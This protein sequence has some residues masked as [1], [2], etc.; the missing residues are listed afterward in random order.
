MQN[1]NDLCEENEHIKFWENCL[2]DLIKQFEIIFQ[3]YDLTIKYQ[4][5]RTSDLGNILNKYRNDSKQ[6]TK[7]PSHIYYLC[8][9]FFDFQSCIWGI[10]YKSGINELYN[11]I[12][13]IINEIIK[14]INKA[15]NETCQTNL[16]IMDECQKLINKIKLQE[17]DFQKKKNL[18][19][20]AQMNQNRIKNTYN[21]AEIKKAD[22]LLAEQIRK[23]EEIKKPMEENKNKLKEMRNKLNSSVRESFEKVVS[24]YFKHLA[25]L[26]Q[27]FFLISNSK[28]NIST[29]IKKS[30]AIIISQLSNLS[31]DLNDYTEKKFG[32]LIGTKYDGFITF[33]S[34]ELL[35]K[36][37]SKLL[38]KISYDI[39]NYIQV[40]M[41]CLRYRKKI[42]KIFLESIKAIIKSEEN[43]KKNFN[44][45]Y[46]NLMNQLNLIKNISDETSKSWHNLFIYETIK[47]NNDYSL[48]VSGIEAY[49]NSARSEYNQLKS[50]WSK[51]E[52]NIKENQKNIIELL[53]EKN[54]DKNKKKDEKFREIIKESI[55]YINNNIYDIR[56]RD[57]KEI[58][59]LSLLFEKMFEKYKILVNKVIDLTEEQIS[60]S[61]YLDLFEECK[62]II[63]KYFNYFKIQNYENFLEKIRVKLLLNT[64]L[65]NEI[66]S[67]DVIEKLNEKFPEKDESI[68]YQNVPNFDDSQ[69]RILPDNDENI[70]EVKKINTLFLESRKSLSKNLF[71]ENINKNPNIKSNISSKNNDIINLNKISNNNLINYHNRLEIEDEKQIEKEI[72]KNGNNYIDEDDYSFDLLDKNKFQELTRIENPYKNIKEEELIR[73]KTINDKKY[74]NNKNENELEEGEKKLDSFNC[75]LKDKI[76]LQ[77]KLNITTK[78]IEFI[79]LFNRNTLIGKT[80]IQ[81]PL[82]D[83]IDIEKKYNLALDNS[84]LIKTEKISYI[85]TNFLS[86]DQCYNILKKEINQMKEKL[87][88]ESNKKENAKKIENI[89]LN[90][91][92]LKKKLFK[93]NE[94]YNMLEN[95]N[96]YLRLKQ[97]TK[98]RMALFSKKYKDEKNF[99]FLPNNKFSKKLME[100]IFKN[101]PLYICF[102]YIC[103]S[104]TQLDE[105][106]YSKGF[107]ESILIENISKEI[108]MIEKDDNNEISNIPDYFINENYIMNLFSSFDK[109]G[110]EILLNEAQNWPHKYEYNCYGINRNV[111][112][113]KPDLYIAYFISPTLLIFDIIG[114]S[115]GLKYMN[116]YI[117]ISRYIFDSS[118]KFNKNKGKFDFITKLTVLHEIQFMPN[119]ILTN[120]DVIKIYTDNES[121]FK[122]KIS[123]KIIDIVDN[124]IQIF[125]DIY[126]KKTEEIFQKK[127][128]LKQN[129]ITDEYEEDKLD[130]IFEDIENNQEESFFFKDI[131]KNKINNSD[132]INQNQDEDEDED[133]DEDNGIK[134]KKIKIKNEKKEKKEKKD[135]SSVNNSFNNESIQASSREKEKEYIFFIV[136]IIILIGI[137][138][139]LLFFKTEKKY[140]IDYNLI[141]NVIILGVV[142]YLVKNK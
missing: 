22:L 131:F 56:E 16:L 48:I 88:E 66:I 6:F 12:H 77:G 54:D 106:G 132:I 89:T 60:N 31:F 17:N 96:F 87:V 113:E 55:K 57:K 24:I 5:Q 117:P 136:I 59:K 41:I 122:N 25:N 42:M 108:I 61:A 44:N 9:I 128:K 84:I 14:D 92:Y 21:I 73:L 97:I 8:E 20:N 104:S 13:P 30:F 1:N 95:I 3:F 127:I 18:M 138:I 101:C 68:N 58:S 119:S 34:E 7:E 40:F 38:L 10:K 82:K 71:L 74:K 2:N 33:N 102:K 51:Y 69:S 47:S 100:H 32:E 85:F 105:L 109:N 107:F 91:I 67:K 112:N 53:K 99:L 90:Q 139:T 45:S 70:S 52:N 110:L 4:N 140:K 133:K 11:K 39:I 86:R 49:I 93:A 121:I 28:I 116:N 120:S 62:I 83:I 134:A 78:K 115:V 126:E 124:Y 135:N 65:Q 26:H 141:I 36:S 79:S 46:K 129:M 130:E 27:I 50:N 111:K 72:G 142:I 29:N 63:V 76:L 37:S 35:N 64:Q 19:D 43:Y 15:K 75:A 98:E 81:I 80:I 103:Y 118:I 137:I 114:Y 125:G 94:V 23:M 123:N